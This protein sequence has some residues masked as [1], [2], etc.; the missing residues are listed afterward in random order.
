MEKIEMIASAERVL[1]I[2]GEEKLISILSNN[3]GLLPKPSSSEE[4][5]E[6]FKKDVGEKFFHMA[7]TGPDMD[8]MI[9]K[10]KRE[11]GKKNTDLLKKRIIEALPE[12]SNIGEEE[13]ECL[14][15]VALKKI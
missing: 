8:G 15:L 10:W 11:R 1:E 14:L 3:E 5:I 7:V 9:D 13:I 4:E 2:M 12:N 6:W